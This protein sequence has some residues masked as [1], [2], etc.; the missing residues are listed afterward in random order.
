MVVLLLLV[1]LVVLAMMVELVVVLVAVTVAAAAAAAAAVMYVCVLKVSHMTLDFS[2][3]RKVRQ[4]HWIVYMTSMLLTA[5]SSARCP[6]V[7]YVKSQ[8]NVRT[9]FFIPIFP[10]KIVP[11]TCP[12]LISNH[13]VTFL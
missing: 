8:N 9:S 4:H 12:F 6:P 7:S 11:R 13:T 10:Q 3:L 5:V 1:M 2:K